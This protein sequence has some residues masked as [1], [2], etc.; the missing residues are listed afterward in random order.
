[1]Q[2]RFQ[3]DILQAMRNKRSLATT[4][5]LE[6]T[7]REANARIKELYACSSDVA[8]I[9]L[10]LRVVVRGEAS[11]FLAPEKECAIHSHD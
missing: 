2:L 7:D 5:Q 10:A 3:D 9:R 1:V 6:P 8:A 4:I 11:P